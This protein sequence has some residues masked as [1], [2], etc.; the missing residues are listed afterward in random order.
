M[1]NGDRI[2]GDVKHIWDG[3]VTIEPEYSDAFEVDLDAIDHIES[4]RELDVKLDDGYDGTGILAGAADDGKQVPETPGGARD[5]ALEEVFEIEEP[6]DYTDCSSHVDY[7]SSL[8]RGNTDSENI[9]LHADGM[10]KRGNHRHLG[11]AT[12]LREEV[13]GVQTQAQDMYVYD[14]N[15]LFSDP[16]FFSSELSFEKDPIIELEHRITLSAG[17]GYDVWN[18]PRKRLSIKLGAGYQDEKF[19]T[20]EN[21]SAVA[22]WGLRFRHE[23]VGGDLAVFHNH[24]I[25]NNISGRTNTIF[26]TTTGLSHEITDLLYATVS[27]DFD[28]NTHPR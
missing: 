18:T 5:I 7:S 4:D 21:E 13:E 28:Y 10:Y 20:E 26:D 1:T 19:N 15:W 2:T 23:F 22:I 9:K 11:E 24:T 25:T 14:Y 17:I 16:W 27:L 8:N 6:E 3:K 12:F